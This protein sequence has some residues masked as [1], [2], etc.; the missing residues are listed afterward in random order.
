MPHELWLERLE[1]VKN[2]RLLTQAADI[3]EIRMEA[4]M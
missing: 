1:I 2:C 3:L 4:M